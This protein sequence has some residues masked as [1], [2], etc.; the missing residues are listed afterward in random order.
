MKTVGIV[1]EYNPFHSGHEYHIKKTREI[2]GEECIIVCAMSGDFVQRGESAMYSKFARAEA[3]ARS[4]ADVVIELC[5]PWA[6]SSAEGFARGSVALLNEAGCEFISFGSEAGDIEALNR[7]ADILADTQINEETK[8]VLSENAAMSYAEA[9]QRAVSREAGDIAALLE[10]PNNILAVEYL[11]AIK[12]L[13]LDIKPL[14]V[15]REGAGHD[16]VSAPLS[17]FPS[18]M[19]LRRKREKGEAIAAFVPGEAEAV[20]TAERA[21]GRELNNPDALEIAILSRLRMLKK[22]DFLALPD[23]QG[24]AGERLYAAVQ[25]EASLQGVLAAAKTKRYALSRLRRMSICAALGITADM[26]ESTPPYIRVLAATERG[27]ALLRTL[28]D[29]EN[30]LPVITKSAAVSALGESAK[31]VFAVGV[32]AHD[33]YTLGF[34]AKE[35]R[36]AGKDWR[37]SPKIVKNS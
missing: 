20:Y 3:A 33:L 16:T 5:A 12:M 9:R 21:A 18:A 24:G 8:K 10:K 31:R 13:A 17:A 14:T 7:L 1:A 2:M 32:S 4:G 22:E 34:S 11:K 28:N 26:A 6:L 27:C 25:R 35:E 36:K 29:R 37:T 30:T 19:E 15:M 23:A